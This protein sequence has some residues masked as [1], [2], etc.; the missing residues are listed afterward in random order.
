[1]NENLPA[2]SAMQRKNNFSIIKNLKVGQK[3]ALMGVVFMIPFAAVTYKLITSV[4][5][6]G[7]EFASKESHGLEYCAP[8]VKLLQD[9]QERR[10]LD[11]LATSQHPLTEELAANATEIQRQIQ[12]VDEA[13]TRLNPILNTTPK[14]EQLKAECREWIK[15]EQGLLATE[16]FG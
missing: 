11:C 10:E 7:V 8:L 14:W 2:M 12:A 6:L 3:L 4:D 13:D 15:Q 16:T 1:M 9:L 5:T